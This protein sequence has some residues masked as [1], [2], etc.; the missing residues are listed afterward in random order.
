MESVQSQSTLRPKLNDFSS[1][2]CMQAM[3]HGMEDAL[4][5]KATTIALTTAGRQRGRDL[6]KSLGLSNKNDI[7]LDV[8]STQFRQALGENG[9]RLCLVHKV[10]KEGDVIKVL[11]TEDVCTAGQNQGSDRKCSYTLGAIW[12]AMEEITGQ[13][14]RGKHTDSILKGSPYNVFELETL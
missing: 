12:G 3:I 5:E 6:V 14:F 13:R 2:I 9:T 7:S 8:I 4:G 1:I 10:L 11:V